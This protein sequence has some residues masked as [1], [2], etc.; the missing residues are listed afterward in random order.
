MRARYQTNPK[1]AAFGLIVS[2]GLILGGQEADRR[3]VEDDAAAVEHSQ[4]LEVESVSTEAGVEA[5]LD[6]LA[7]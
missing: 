4:V 2:L 7:C 1:V 3:P 5:R 6:L